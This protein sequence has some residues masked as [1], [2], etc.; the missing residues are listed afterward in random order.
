MTGWYLHAAKLGAAAIA[1]FAIVSAIWLNGQAN[2][3]AD[4]Q[5]EWD[6]QQKVDAEAVQAQALKTLETERGHA[7]LSAQYRETYL[8][9][10]DRARRA[11]ADGMRSAGYPDGGGGMPPTDEDRPRADG[12]TPDPLPAGAGGSLVDDCAVTTAQ[13]VSLQRQLREAGQ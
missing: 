13:L 9:M 4:I 6:A 3:R 2:G 12:A 8:A 5:A 11:R 10:L 1:L 7:L